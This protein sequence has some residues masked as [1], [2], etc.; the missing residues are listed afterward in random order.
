[1]TLYTR[2]VR[3]CRERDRVDDLI[4]LVHLL[5]RLTTYPSCRCKP[6]LACCVVLAQR[7]SIRFRVFRMHKLSAKLFRTRASSSFLS[8]GHPVAKL[9]YCF[10]KV[11][12]K[13]KKYYYYINLLNCVTQFSF[14]CSIEFDFEKR[15]IV[16]FLFNLLIVCFSFFLFDLL[17][18]QWP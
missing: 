4:K 16:L 3:S 10:D 13:G 15:A 7:D 1:M 14:S 6:F 9:R 11:R 2:Y 17:H 8:A 18:I 12:E 5:S